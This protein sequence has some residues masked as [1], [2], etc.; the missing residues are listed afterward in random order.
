MYVYMCVC[1]YVYIVTY[2]CVY[3]SRRDFFDLSIPFGIRRA[4]FGKCELSVNDFGYAP[5]G[6]SIF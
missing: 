1:V 5:S 3:V 2:V 6:P 4:L